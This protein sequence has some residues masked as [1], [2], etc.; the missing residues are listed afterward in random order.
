MAQIHDMRRQHDRSID[1][2]FYRA[3]SVALR[4]QA[5]RDMF[6]FKEAFGFIIATFATALVL[7]LIAVAA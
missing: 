1:F 3:Q 4:S 6:K 5:R 7:A 2:D